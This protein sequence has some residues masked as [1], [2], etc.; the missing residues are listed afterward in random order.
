MIQPPVCSKA[1]QDMIKKLKR[2]K[3]PKEY[4]YDEED[5][6][7]PTKSLISKEI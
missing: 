5:F 2:D 6:D 7:L 1:Y 3:K 4:G